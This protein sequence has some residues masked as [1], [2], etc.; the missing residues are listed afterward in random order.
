MGFVLW[1]SAS[2]LSAPQSHANIRVAAMPSQWDDLTT[3]PLA[4]P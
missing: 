2:S 1:S 3:L 4:K